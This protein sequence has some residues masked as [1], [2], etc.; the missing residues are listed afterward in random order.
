MISCPTVRKQAIRFHYD[1]S[2]LFYRLLWGPH[3]HHGLWS[4]NET[5]QVAQQQLTDTLADLAHVQNGAAVLDV[6]CGMGGSS[7]H[8]AKTRNCLVTGLT[9]SPVQRR[10]ATLAAR[11]HHVSPK[12][13]FLCVDAE[14]V[15]FEP[16]SFD[17]VW[18]IECTEH[19]F[20][21]GAFFRRAAKWLKPGG[22]VA[23]CAW[24]AGESL[25]SEAARQQVFDV[26]EGFLCP[27]LGTASDYQQWFVEAG[28]RNAVAQD[29]TDRVQ[30]TWAICDRRIRRTGLKWVGPAF[31]RDVQLFLQRFPTI[32]NAY[33]SG[34]MR[35]GCLVAEKPEQNT[36]QAACGEV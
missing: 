16:N 34:A 18:S 22:R 28:L 4:G 9:L 12:T 13:R 31:G 21:K 24:L 15:E 23:I 6:G 5:P 25:A 11:W 26:C 1:L 10:W 8:L 2:T 32:L 29:W 35:Y 19:L 7:I 30:E 27:S 17:V 20:D 33:R 14:G 3:L 36:P